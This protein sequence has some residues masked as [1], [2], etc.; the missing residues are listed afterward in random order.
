MMMLKILKIA[1][2]PALTQIEYPQKTTA[3]WGPYMYNII[4]IVL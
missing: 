3:Q 2:L 4:Y 1:H